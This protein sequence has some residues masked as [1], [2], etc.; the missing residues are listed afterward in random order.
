VQLEPDN[1]GFLLSL[2]QAQMR[3]SKTNEARLTLR[4][5]LLPH[6]EPKLRAF[7]QEVLKETGAQG[8]R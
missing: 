3:S 1:P 5:L 2:A 6:T 8:A 7:A 4:P